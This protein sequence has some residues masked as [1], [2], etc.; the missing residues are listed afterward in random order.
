MSGARR[1][2]DDAMIF[3]H[4][5]LGF[6]VAELPCGR[7]ALPP[8]KKRRLQA[9]ATASLRVE[10]FAATQKSE[11]HRPRFLLLRSGPEWYQA[12]FVPCSAWQLPGAPPFSLLLRRRRQSNI[13]EW[14][15]AECVETA[16]YAEIT[17]PSPIEP[18]AAIL[19]RPATREHAAALAGA[20]SCNLQSVF[21]DR[22]RCEGRCRNRLRVR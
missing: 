1:Q 12:R 21:L 17:N 13:Q 11:I 14:E 16:C 3:S 6:K 4:I 8:A 9:V 7:S 22:A 19:T 15:R 18:V 5:P 20:S 2:A 10:K